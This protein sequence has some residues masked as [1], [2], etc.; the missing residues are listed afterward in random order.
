MGVAKR[1]FYADN[2]SSQI[3]QQDYFTLSGTV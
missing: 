3:F 1:L 2:Y